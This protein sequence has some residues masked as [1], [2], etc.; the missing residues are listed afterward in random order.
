MSEKLLDFS[1]PHNSPSI[2][3]GPKLSNLSTYIAPYYPKAAS[4]TKHAFGTYWN[5]ERFTM[6]KD[7]STFH[8][9]DPGLKQLFTTNLQYQMSLDSLVLVGLSENLGVHCTN[10]EFIR[11]YFMQSYHEHVHSTSYSYIVASIYA[12]PKSVEDDIKN[13]PVIIDRISSLN[14][15]YANL[16]DDNIEDALLQLYFTESVSFVLSFATTFCINRYLKYGIQNVARI[17]HEIDREENIHAGMGVLAI[18]T[19][20]SASYEGVRLISDD[21]D[22]KARD[23]ARDLYTQEVAWAASLYDIY[24]LKELH[25]DI[26]TPFT[27]LNIHKAL[28]NINVPSI[29]SD[30]EIANLNRSIVNYYKF[31]TDPGGTRHAGQESQ[32]NEY[33]VGTVYMDV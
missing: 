9:M 21:F 8:S 24:P 2:F 15:I 5:P 3:G 30:A 29:F 25:P 6:T 18:N 7:A 23:L 13:N 33:V 20:R 1:R 4:L 17:I 16:S 10:A 26:A 19:M 11:M 14:Q 31:Q 22:S 28:K 32:N 12:D 27:K